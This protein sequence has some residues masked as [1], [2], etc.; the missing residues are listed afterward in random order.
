M[1]QL[2]GASRNQPPPA[3]AA[4]KAVPIPPSDP[5]E[6]IKARTEGLAG[7]AQLAMFGSLIKGNMA[8]V[9]A[10]SMYAPKLCEESAILAEKNENFGRTLDFIA[11]AGP[12]T[13]LLTAAV[14]FVLQI[15]ANHKRLDPA[16]AAH[17]GVLSPEV[18]A[19]RARKELAEMELRAKLEQ[20]AAEAELA[21]ITEEFM[22]GQADAQERQQQ[23][24]A[25]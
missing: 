20:Q 16:L 3:P 14:P 25:V 24:A 21:R 18:L 5:A 10:I 15:A 11:M 7:I 6:R 19:A 23:A 13:A 1:A 17:F 12:Y 2:R 4:K 22:R 9:G 8:D